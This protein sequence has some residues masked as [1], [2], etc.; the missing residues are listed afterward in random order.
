MHS[1]GGPPC[2]GGAAKGDA[3]A[4]GKDAAAGALPKAEDGG[5]L[6]KAPEGAAPL[7]GGK[8]GSFAL[9]ALPGSGA[10]NAPCAKTWPALNVTTATNSGAMN[11]RIIKAVPSGLQASSRQESDSSSVFYDCCKRLTTRGMGR[12][13]GATSPLNG[14]NRAISSPFGLKRPRIGTLTRNAFA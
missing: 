1:S 12:E 2:V 6:P 8:A 7:T 10:G 14:N 5:G 3:P 11:W 9:P 13:R 4:P